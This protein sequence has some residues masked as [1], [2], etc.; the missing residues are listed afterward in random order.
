[1]ETARVAELREQYREALFG[2]VLPFWLRHS[3]DGEYGGYLTCLDRDGSVYGTD[4]SMWM[5]GRGTWLLSK[6]YN[7]VEKREEWLD[8][9]TCGYE[10]LTRY[11][12]DDDGR[13]FFAATREGRPLR[14]RRYLFTE[15]FGAIACAQYAQATG[16]EGALQR[17]RDTYR[18][19]IDLYR[20]PGALP[21]KIIRETRV[22]KAHAMPMIL[23]STSQELRQV[24][25][26][27]LYGEVIDASLDEVLNDFVKRQERALFETVGP[28]GERLDSP[29]GRCICPG[30]AIETAWFIM[31]EGRH[32]E[33]ASLIERACEILDWSLDWGWDAEHGGILYFVDAEGKPPEQLEWDMKLWWPHTEALY[34]LLLAHHLTGAAKYA[35]WYETVHEWTFGRFPDPEHGEWFGYCHRD[36]SLA[37]RLKGSMWKGPFHVPRGLLYCWRLLEEMAG[38]SSR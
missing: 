3:L 8:A 10:F 30:H 4:K 33:D 11:G 38:R 13:M 23:L 27:P 36:G 34:A 12:F 6:L 24:D 22:T 18:L 5:Q 17:A 32:R 1:L 7:T 16:D 25:P 2:D 19:T 28:N 29:E 14:K 21:P 9:A 31:H 35:Q 37:S 26:D 15:T 20:T